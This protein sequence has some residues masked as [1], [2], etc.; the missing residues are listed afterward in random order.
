MFDHCRGTIKRVRRAGEN[1]PVPVA[2]HFSETPWEP[3]VGYCRAIRVGS[4]I[5]VSGTVGIGPDGR[6]PE[7]AYAQATAAIARAI[8]AVEALGGTR[9]DVVRTRMF[10][11]DPVGDLAEIARAHREA[12]GAHPPVTSLIGTTAL[13]APEFSFEIEIEADTAA[14]T[15]PESTTLDFGA[16]KRHLGAP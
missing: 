14:S 13:V 15:T 16:G 5:S 12:F 10:A 9:Q 8:A 1:G 7:G 11:T 2:R 4:H 3:E 6:A